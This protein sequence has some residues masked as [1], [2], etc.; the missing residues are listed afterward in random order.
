[1][2]ARLF[3]VKS[4]ALPV[5]PK[6]AG[7][8]NSFPQPLIL[9]PNARRSYVVMWFAIIWFVEATELSILEAVPKI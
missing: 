8:Q 6:H 9:E 2:C 3:P 4:F 5:T 1:M 7:E